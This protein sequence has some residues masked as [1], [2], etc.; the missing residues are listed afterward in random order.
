MEP[1]TIRTVAFDTLPDHARLWVFGTARPLSDAEAETILGR[2]DRFLRE[3]NAHGHPVVGS[4]DLRY[5]RFLLIAADERA[6]GVSGC[7]TDSLYRVLKEL[8]SNLHTGLLDTSLVFYRDVDDEIR[9][10]SRPDFRE[11]AMEGA[12]DGET[13]VFD[14]TVRTTG[15][16]REAW[17]KPLASS[18]HAKAF[19]S[20][21]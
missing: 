18:W 3:W 17:E 7:S 21:E 20:R 16:L 10:V 1:Q 14:N 12:V 11:L 6:T 4:R 5:G 15:D 2:V 9:A 19:L 8:E 13:T